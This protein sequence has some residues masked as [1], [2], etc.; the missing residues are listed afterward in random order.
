MSMAL[1][2]HPTVMSK[3]FR[4]HFRRRANVAQDR[5]RKLVSFHG[6]DM[7]CLY[8]LWCRGEAVDQ[9]TNL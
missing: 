9:P 6:L 4:S 1:V 2:A 3:I 8:D 7:D 5:W